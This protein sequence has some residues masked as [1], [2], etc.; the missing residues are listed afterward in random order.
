MIEFL[1]SIKNAIELFTYFMLTLKEIDHFDCFLLN[2]SNNLSILSFK[3]F[4]EF[5]KEI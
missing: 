5:M 3:S 1:A 2:I 4:F